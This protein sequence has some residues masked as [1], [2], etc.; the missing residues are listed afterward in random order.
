[1]SLSIYT[2]TQ[3]FAFHL[4]S[5]TLFCLF[6]ITSYIS[7]FHY[8]SILS[9]FNV[10]YRKGGRVP[11]AGTAQGVSLFPWF[12]TPSYSVFSLY[13]RPVDALS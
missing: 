6:A 13:T 4:H 7:L 8:I 11:L 5:D 2:L 3:D 1:M 9:R 12:T 10:R